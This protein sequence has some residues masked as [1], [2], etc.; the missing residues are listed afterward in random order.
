MSDAAVS[1]SKKGAGAIILF[2][3]LRLVVVGTD[4]EDASLLAMDI[5]LQVDEAG[6][7]QILCLAGR[8]LLTMRC[9]L[10]AG[11]FRRQGDVLL[12]ATSLPSS[13]SRGL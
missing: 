13:I 7:C 8:L 2:P 11:L 4:V 3:L 9:T 1:L 5:A 10:A 6:R 12:P